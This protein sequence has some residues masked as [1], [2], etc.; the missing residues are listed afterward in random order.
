M[1]ITADIRMRIRT[2]NIYQ[3]HA[4]LTGLG[5]Y[6]ISWLRRLNALSMNVSFGE[7]SGHLCR[8]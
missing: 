1:S 2:L 8:S 4:L 7:Y 3:A 6:E 5:T